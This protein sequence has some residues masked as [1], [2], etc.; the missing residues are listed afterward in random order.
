MTGGVAIGLLSI[1]QGVG[2]QLP[3]WVYWTIAGFAAFWS[4]FMAWR[5]EHG[6][7]AALKAKIETLSKNTPAQI[8]VEPT[9]NVKCLGVTIDATAVSI[10][11]QNVLKPGATVAEFRNA[12][13][14]VEFKRQS[15]GEIWLTLFPAKWI[16]ENELN[17]SIGVEPISAF[18]A[19]Y[20]P[21]TEHKWKAL[22]SE[23]VTP[24]DSCWRE[25]IGGINLSFDEYRIKAT[26]V[27]ENNLSIEPIEGTLNLQEDGNA[28][29]NSL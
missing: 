25:R 17:V 16:L 8:P 1:Y 4:C 2:H 19:A 15:N 11:F 23:A 12:R 21:V 28:V 10:T 18:I 20:Y 29:W 3:P 7:V 22:V 13:L 24:S 9:H 27:G 5:D 6:Q 26:L 14:M